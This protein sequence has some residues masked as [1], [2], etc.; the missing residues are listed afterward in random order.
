[1]NGRGREEK[2]LDK[3][4]R[5]D[6]TNSRRIGS[7]SGNRGEERRGEWVEVRSRGDEGRMADEGEGAWRMA[8]DGT[9]DQGGG[10]TSL[11]RKCQLNK[12]R[13]RGL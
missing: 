10:T 9:G 12:G 1:M 6:W 7:R 5:R 8:G 2:M 3:G 11:M 4:K 13:Q